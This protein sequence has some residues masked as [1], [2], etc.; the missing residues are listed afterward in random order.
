MY[1]CEKMCEYD[2][3]YVVMQYEFFVV[4]VGVCI[5]EVCLCVVDYF[6]VML[7]E[8]VIDFVVDYCVDG[9]DVDCCLCVECVCVDQCVGCEYYGVGWYDCVD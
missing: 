5:V 6:V 3:F 4:C 8:F 2:V 9:C 1:W 7:F